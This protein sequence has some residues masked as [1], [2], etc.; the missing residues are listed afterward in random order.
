M[1][2]SQIVRGFIIIFRGLKSYCNQPLVMGSILTYRYPSNSKFLIFT[3]L[4]TP[5]Q[6]LKCMV[7]LSL[8]TCICHLNVGKI[9]PA[10]LSVKGG[11]AFQSPG[12]ALRFSQTVYI[13][14]PPKQLEPGNTCL[15]QD[16][17]RCEKRD[18]LVV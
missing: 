10:T 15:Q 8:F 13:V 17:I 6:I 16:E 18:S 2:V 11:V 14:A 12:G 9:T 1:N 4:D 5:P 3:P 7:Y